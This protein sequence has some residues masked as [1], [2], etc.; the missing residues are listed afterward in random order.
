[1][2]SPLAGLLLL[3]S[4]ACGAPTAE[5]QGLTVENLTDLTLRTDRNLYDATFSGGRGTYRTYS[6]TLVARF[7]N[8]TDQPLYLNRCYPETSY[9]IY[10]VVA[11]NA[12]L[13]A[14]YN[15][16]WA[17]VGH[18]HPIVVDRG[19]A[20]VDTLRI[21]GPNAWDGS[22]NEP[23]GTLTGPF[24]LSYSIATCPDPHGCGAMP[25]SV[26]SNTFEVRLKPD[27]E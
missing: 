4:A 25:L 14:G 8:G 18:D 3:A 27:G 15:P 5:H 10:G 6:L 26:Q 12:N 2:R 17:C 24:R 23:L 11:T 19:E 20:R 22:T 13:D 7:T 16:V 21:A 1:M 9:P